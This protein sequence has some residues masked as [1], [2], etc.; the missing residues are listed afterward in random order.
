MVVILD[1]VTFLI[2]LLSDNWAASGT[3]LVADGVITAANNATPKFIDIRSIEPKEGR[4]VDIDSQSVVVVYEESASTSY[5]TIDYAVRNENFTF[6][7]HIRVLHRRDFTSNTA[8][9]DR[10]QA[11]YR[12][13]RYILENNSL[14]P[15]VTTVESGTTYKENADIITLTSRSE[16]NDR[17][18]RLLG[19]KL[20]VEMKRFGRST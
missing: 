9:R 20:A 17:G 1:E 18:K 16:A 15:T 2:R 4:R 7:V 13:A 5:P 3:Q 14:R 10:L 8:S 11:L 6:T 19:Y 12:I